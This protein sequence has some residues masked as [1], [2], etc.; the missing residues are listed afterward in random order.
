MDF[1]TIVDS[2]TPSAAVISVEKLDNGNYGKVRIVTGNHQYTDTIES[3]SWTYVHTILSQNFISPR[4]KHA[5]QLP[6]APAGM[7][8]R[9]CF[10]QF[11]GYLYLSVI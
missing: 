5:L 4:N 3:E 2:I 1:K 7:A 11:F 9:L 8:T 6:P 10:N